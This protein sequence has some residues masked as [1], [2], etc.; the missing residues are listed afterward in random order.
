MHAGGGPMNV[1][2]GQIDLAAAPI[3]GEQEVERQEDAA[4]GIG[5]PPHLKA[6]AIQG[7]GPLPKENSNQEPPLNPPGQPRKIEYADDKEEEE[8]DEE[9]DVPEDHRPPARV[10]NNPAND[11]GRDHRFGD[12]FKRDM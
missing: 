11:D 9:I 4:A 12:G 1:E 6:Q 5:P 7:I 8:E 10:L 2:G 3:G